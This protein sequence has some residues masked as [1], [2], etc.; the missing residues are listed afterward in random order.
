MC[1][2]ESQLTVCSVAA[3]PVKLALLFANLKL[4]CTP[5]TVKSV[6]QPVSAMTFIDNKT[7]HL[8]KDDILELRIYSI[9]RFTCYI[10]KSS[11]KNSSRFLK[12]Y[13]YKMSSRL[14]TSTADA[15]V[16]DKD[17]IKLYHSQ[18]PPYLIICASGIGS[19]FFRIVNL[20]RCKYYQIYH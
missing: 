11:N 16:T 5:V 3:A 7:T 8:L 15:I 19:L 17:I 18:M 4:E 12:N 2:S 20:K 14:L 9:T 1:V 6:R 13:Q 10:K